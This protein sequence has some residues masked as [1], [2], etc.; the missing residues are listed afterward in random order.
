MLKIFGYLEIIGAII[1][2]IFFFM[3][4]QVLLGFVMLLNLVNGVALLTIVKNSEGIEEMKKTI[5]K[6][7]EEN[8]KNY[9]EL[10]HKIFKTKIELKQEVNPKD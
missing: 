9:R 1:G 5:S 6:A 10:E 8:K 3:D 7:E 2:S 4:S